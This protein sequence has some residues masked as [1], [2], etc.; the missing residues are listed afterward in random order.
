MARQTIKAFTSQSFINDKLIR[1]VIRQ[2]GGWGDFQESADDIAQHG[3]DVGWSVFTYYTDTVAFAERNKTLII[4]LAKEQANDYG[5][6]MYEMIGSFN[7][8][9]LESWEVA[10]ALH[11]KTSPEHTTVYNALAW[12][13][14]EEV[15]REYQRIIEG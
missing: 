7:C 3:A 15:A 5:S 11:E 8:L 6:N 2:F 14:L 13:A 10:E 4:E 9:K 12:Y 1:A